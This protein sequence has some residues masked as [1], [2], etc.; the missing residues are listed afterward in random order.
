MS[1]A[2]TA[3]L[4]REIIKDAAISNVIGVAAF[5]LA[6]AFGAF[7]RI[8]LLFT[9]VP[10]TGQTF[11]VLLSGAVLGRRWGAFSQFG[12][13]L[14]G[15]GGLPI[16]S[17]AGAGLGHIFGPSGGYIIGFPIAAWVVGRLVSHIERTTFWRIY[18]S[19]II[20]ELIIYTLGCIQLAFIAGL[21]VKAAITL[22]ALPFIPGDLI[23]IFV[24]TA[25]YLR[26][27]GRV[28]EIFALA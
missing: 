24:A 17:G 26:I 6:T 21:N 18:I 23:K 9:P 12:Y 25:I 14:L 1:R 7:I 8:P 3:V 20:G 28:R 16:F 22:G 13:L 4:N 15:L 27:K 10:I 11:F 2:I 19:M 5:I